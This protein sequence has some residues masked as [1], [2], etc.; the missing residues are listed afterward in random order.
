MPNKSGPGIYKV[1]YAFPFL[2]RPQVAEHVLTEPGR[3]I[4]C[5]SAMVVP[6]SSHHAGDRYRLQR[7]AYNNPPLATLLNKMEHDAH[8]LYNMEHTE[9]QPQGEEQPRGSA[10]GRSPSGPYLYELDENVLDQIEIY[11]DQSKNEHYV[12]VVK[13]TH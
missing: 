12:V 7:Q 13:I 2:A 1:L 10:E 11:D 3:L 4:L 6:S 9:T 5:V 8:M